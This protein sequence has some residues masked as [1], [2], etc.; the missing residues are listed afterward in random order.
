MRES[1]R[2]TF[3]RATS[4]STQR[5]LAVAIQLITTGARM[6]AA[7]SF[8]VLEVSGPNG[9]AGRSWKESREWR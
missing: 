2:L 6:L 3:S 1:N 9:V 8:M 7:V 5:D 4:A